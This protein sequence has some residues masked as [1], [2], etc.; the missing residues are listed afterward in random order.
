MVIATDDCIFC[1][2]IKGELPSRKLIETDHVIGILDTVPATEGHCLIIPKRHVKYWNDMTY[3][4]TAQV[5]NA[6]RKVAKQLKNA[7]KPEYVCMFIRGGRV[8]HT[9]VVLFPSWEGDKLTGFPQSTLGT[10]KI[11]LDKLHDKLKNNKSI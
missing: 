7:L 11:D 4:E 10:P 2:I 9:H 1:E 6:A 8:K 3:M 5:F